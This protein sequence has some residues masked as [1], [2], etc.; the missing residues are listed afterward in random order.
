METG[1]IKL[2]KRMF[3]VLLLICLVCYMAIVYFYKDVFMVN[4]WINGIYCTGKTVEEV[5]TELLLQTKAPF[6]TIINKEGASEVI[7]M[8]KVG[9]HEDYIKIGRA[10]CRERV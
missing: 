9:Y 4:T 1:L 2:L 8:A 6:L 10:S 7:D 3:L 5:N